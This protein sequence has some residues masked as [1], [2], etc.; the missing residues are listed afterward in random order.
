MCRR[1]RFVLFSGPRLSGKT[2]AS[3]HCVVDHAWR[4][5]RGNI[6]IVSVS[7][8]AGLDSGIWKKL[9]NVTIP[10]WINSGMGMKWAKKPYIANVTKRPACSVTNAFGTITEL[11]LDSLKF[12]QEVE[13]RFKNREFS[14]MYVPELSHFQEKKTFDIWAECLRGSHLK[15]E[16]FLFLA[17]TNPADDGE[18][19]WI[20]F[21]WFVLP[22]LNFNEYCEFCRK[23]DLPTLTEGAFS[24]YKS[25]IGSLTFNIE[26]NIF[27]TRNRIELL[28]GTYAGNQDLYDRYILGLWKKSSMDALFYKVFRPNFH[29]VG[30]IET[31]GNPDPELMMPEKGAS[32]LYT[33][34]DPG[35]GV[36]SA[37]CIVEKTHGKI[38]LPSGKLAEKSIYKVLDE[39]VITGQDHSLDEFT[40]KCVEKME[41]WEDKC[42]QAFDWEHWSDQSVFQMREPRHQK[43]YHQI[44]YEASGGVVTLKAAE[45]GPG[46]VKQRIDLFRKLLFEGRIF[47]NND[48]CAKTIE[49]CRSMRA[50]TSNLQPIAKGSPH[51]HPFDALL[52]CVASL[53][54]DELDD[55]VFERVRTSWNEKATESS[56]V[57]VGI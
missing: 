46:S 18:D 37:F 6:S 8:S 2:E 21:M 13:D 41:W 56:L 3:T 10:N 5:D 31:P 36:N 54:F 42:G 30:E 28:E 4:T 48:R 34:W 38:T 14:M 51:K 44:V 50:G 24:N 52:Y 32:R 15:D 40:E 45:R 7:Q 1:K 29:I 39:L 35:A 16:Q 33:G 57:S 22:A 9:I 23:K 25:S 17:D 47:F 19:S 43:Y 55:A 53:A 26:H 49:M 20:Y 12:E 11:Q 27:L